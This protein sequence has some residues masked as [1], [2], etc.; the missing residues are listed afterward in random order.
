MCIAKVVAVHTITSDGED[1]DNR[2]EDIG[3]ELVVEKPHSVGTDDNDGFQDPGELSDT[4]WEGSGTV[5][6]TGSW[7]R[8]LV[9]GTQ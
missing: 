9:Q 8:T 7:H 6:V 5:D 1:G 2:E 3:G 4:I